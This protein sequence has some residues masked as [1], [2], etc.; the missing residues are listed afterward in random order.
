MRI[1]LTG[2][3][4]SGKSTVAGIFAEYGA[5]VVDA[6]QISR[7]VVE[8]GSEALR[9]I[10]SA[11]GPEMVDADGALRRQRLAQVVFRDPEAL[12]RLN[13][14]VHP[15]VRE[16]ELA[17]TE[18]YEKE[19]A[20]LIV[21]DVPLLFEK[22]LETLVDRVVVVVAPEATRRQRLIANRGLDLGEIQRRTAAQASQED[23]R[24]RADYVIDNGGDLESTRRQTRQLVEALLREAIDAGAV[25]STEGGG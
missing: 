3:F 21:W 25:P 20:A 2:T 15:R 19:G 17:L 1:G 6:D 7:Q 4:G 8:P 22:G 23:K 14:I 9:Q 18:R 11:F 16:V 5:R 24:D 12:E 10:V 13:A